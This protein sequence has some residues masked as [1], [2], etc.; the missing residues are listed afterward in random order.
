MEQTGKTNLIAKINEPS[1]SSVA[2]SMRQFIL[3]SIQNQIE[4]GDLIIYTSEDLDDYCR[5][6]TE[7]MGESGCE[8]YLFKC[9]VTQNELD[10]AKEPIVTI[11]HRKLYKELHYIC[12]LIEE[13]YP[14]AQSNIY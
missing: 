11:A 8:I 5:W 13:V 7:R 4:E 10:E 6:K 3:D 9:G 14:N 12:A 2:D 1:L